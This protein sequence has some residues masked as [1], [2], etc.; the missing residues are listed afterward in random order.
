MKMRRRMAV[1]IMYAGNYLRDN[2]LSTY[3]MLLKSNPAMSWKSMSDE[4]LKAFRPPNFQKKIRLELDNLRQNQGLE[5]YI[6]SFRMI[7]NQIENISD[8]DK[9]HKFTCGLANKT[10][11]YV[12]LNNPDSLDKAIELAMNYDRNM[13]GTSDPVNVNFIKQNSNRYKNKYYKDFRY[14]NNGLPD[15]ANSQSANRTDIKCHNCNGYGHIAKFCPTNNKHHSNRTQSFNGYR[16][17][18]NNT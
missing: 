2:A 3:R 10:K 4:L 7:M 6:A 9:I 8:V 5:E 15:R 18:N 1:Y 13:F 16:E 11:A 17:S 12:N 14:K